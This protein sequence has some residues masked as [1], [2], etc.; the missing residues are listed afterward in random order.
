MERLGKHVDAGAEGARYVGADEHNGFVGFYYR[1]KELRVRQFQGARFHF[2]SK[3]VLTTHLPNRIA[4]SMANSL[5]NT[6]WQPCQQREWYPSPPFPPSS[7][8]S[9]TPYP[10]LFLP[11][12]NVDPGVSR[13]RRLELSFQPLDNNYPR[14]C[15]STVHSRTRCRADEL[16][17]SDEL[18]G[19]GAQLEGDP[20]IVARGSTMLPTSNR[21]S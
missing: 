18:V 2:A 16:R 3:D 4:K 19:R 15:E 20:I 7:M 17:F 11:F 6:N 12:Y 9:S 13:S 10:I 21:I 14:S 5:R 1:I 8:V